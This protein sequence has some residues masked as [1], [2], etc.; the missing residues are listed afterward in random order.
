MTE[1]MGSFSCKCGTVTKDGPLYDGN[2]WVCLTLEQARDLE[3]SIA[4]QASSETSAETVEEI[5]AR[6]INERFVPMFRCPTCW[7][8]YVGKSGSSNTWNV[9]VPDGEISESDT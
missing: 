2:S 6:E 5:V 9:F 4:Q 8:M 3:S 1:T 7:R